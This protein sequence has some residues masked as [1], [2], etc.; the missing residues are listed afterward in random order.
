MGKRRRASPQPVTESSL[1]PEDEQWRI[2]RQSGILHN[3]EQATEVE[4]GDDDS[5]AERASTSFGQES[6][7]E[8]HTDDL[9]ERI[10]QA[11][12]LVVPMCFLYAMMDMSVLRLTSRRDPCAHRPPR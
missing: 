8:G 4:L 1:I 12:L 6:G 11:V 2:I 10:F 5:D 9:S 7:Q 3:V